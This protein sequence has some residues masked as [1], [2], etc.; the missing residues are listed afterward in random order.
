LS[1]SFGLVITQ[2]RQ[3]AWP[4]RA[5]FFCGAEVIEKIQPPHMQLAASAHVSSWHTFPVAALLPRS[6]CSW[7][8]VLR[9]NQPDTPSEQ[10]KIPN[11][12]VGW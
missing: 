5:T 7:I 11:S 4:H 1:R 12:D 8:D 9:L 2:D 3:D 10:E 6:V